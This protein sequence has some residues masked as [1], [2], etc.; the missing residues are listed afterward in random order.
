MSACYQNAWL[1]AHSMATPII[2][3]RE[4]PCIPA[5]TQARFAQ[6]DCNSLRVTCADGTVVEWYKGGTV[7]Q[8]LPNGDK[9]IFPGR[10]TYSSFLKGAYTLPEFFLGYL[11]FQP[12]TS[13]NYFEFHGNG[14]VMYRR[15]GLTLFWSPEFPARE[16]TGEIQYLV[17][18]SEDDDEYQFWL[19]ERPDSVS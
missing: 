4:R 13:G 3:F 15:N 9:I 17:Y 12:Q 2:T 16:V 10:P 14:A 8:K 19:S 6:D 5:S 1:L 18:D 11:S 7:Q